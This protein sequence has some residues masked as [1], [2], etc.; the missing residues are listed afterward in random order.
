[1]ITLQS[2]ES[3]NLERVRW[4]KIRFLDADKVNEMG[5][6]KMKQFSAPG[7]K[8]ASIPLKNLEGVEGQEEAGSVEGK[9]EAGG[10]GEG[11]EGKETQWVEGV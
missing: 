1:M 11:A 8:T 5:R 6:E 2:R 10:S 3:K 7:S 9:P 4:V